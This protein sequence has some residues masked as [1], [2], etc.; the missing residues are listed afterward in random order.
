[1]NTP[2]YDALVAELRHQRQNTIPFLRPAAGP[3]PPAAREA[4]DW[5]A[6]AEPSDPAQARP[7]PTPHGLRGIANILAAAHTGLAASDPRPFVLTTG[8]VA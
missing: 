2:I 5:F 8:T 7:E 1:M 4:Y 3:T 6:P